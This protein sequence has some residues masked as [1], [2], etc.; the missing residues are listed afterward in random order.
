MAGE[1]RAIFTNMCMIYDDDGN[2]LV[3]DRVNPDWSGVTFPG[4][5]VEH[6]LSIPEPHMVLE[7]IYRRLTNV[8]KSCSSP[9]QLRLASLSFLYIFPKTS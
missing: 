3:Q 7:K 9:L 1:E 2:I 5:H 8:I 6:S 4:G